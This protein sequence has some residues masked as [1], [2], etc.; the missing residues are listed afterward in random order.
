MVTSSRIGNTIVDGLWGPAKVFIA[1]NVDGGHLSMGFF[2]FY[3]S[4]NFFVYIYF[5]LYTPVYINYFIVKC[6][7]VYLRNLGT[8]YLY[9]LSPL[10]QSILRTANKV[11]F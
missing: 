10:I 6:V 9:L 7:C 5:V 1:L 8:H 2:F 3:Y 11:S 4:F